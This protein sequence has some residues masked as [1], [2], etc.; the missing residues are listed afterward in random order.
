MSAS[1]V[2]NI[3]SL[4]AFHTGI[5]RLSGDWDKTLQEVKMIVER[6]ESYFSEDVPRY[7]RHQKRLAERELTEARENLSIKQ[8]STRP[9]DRPAATEAA[10]R[11]QLAQRRLSECETKQ[12]QAKAWRIEVSRQCDQV[13]A[14]LAD[15]LEHCHVVLPGAASELRTLIAQLRR[16]A[17]Q[18]RRDRGT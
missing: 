18:E 10:K 17:E 8:A 7:W 2:R 1:H 9:S 3:E 5:V 16:Y 14:P 4:A 11:V 12:R 6:A 15:V 13:L